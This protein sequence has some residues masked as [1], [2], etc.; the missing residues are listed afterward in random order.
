MKKKPLVIKKKRTR[1]P[2]AENFDALVLF[3]QEHHRLPVKPEHP[4]LV[5]WMG[6]VIK[7]YRAKKTETGI[8]Y[9]AQH[10][11]LYLESF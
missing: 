4:Q 9:T 6:M 1:T 3:M 5:A 2:F 10:H 7:M 11:R 8:Y